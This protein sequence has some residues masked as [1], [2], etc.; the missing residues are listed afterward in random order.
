MVLNRQRAHTG[1]G[2]SYIVARE[3]GEIQRRIGREAVAVR[4]VGGWDGDGRGGR[5]RWG[6]WAKERNG[7]L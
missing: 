5:E 7:W 3:K 1:E 6:W 2:G 4:S